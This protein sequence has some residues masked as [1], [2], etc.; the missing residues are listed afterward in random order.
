M[1]KLYSTIFLWNY[2][3]KIDIYKI[4][5]LFKLYLKNF[6]MYKYFSNAINTVFLPYKM[7]VFP[8]F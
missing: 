8:L 3:H 5:Y 4:F 1:R 6:G 2:F 7:R